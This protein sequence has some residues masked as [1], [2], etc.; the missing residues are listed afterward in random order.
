MQ[1]PYLTDRDIVYLFVLNNIELKRDKN[2]QTLHG[3]VDIVSGD[4]E[5]CCPNCKRYVRIA[6]S[7]DLKVI[8]MRLMKIWFCFKKN[9]ADRIVKKQTR[10][11][12]TNIGVRSESVGEQQLEYK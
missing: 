4:G 11:R 3:P 10:A 6:I 7:N 5:H 2:L 8:D 12:E 1:K 9:L